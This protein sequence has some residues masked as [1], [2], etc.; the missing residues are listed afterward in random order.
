MFP[1]IDFGE[2]MGTRL[3]LLTIM[4]DDMPVMLAF[5]RDNLGFLVKR[6][7]GGWVSLQ[8]EGMRLALWERK[9]LISQFPNVDFPAGLNGTFVLA[10]TFS[11]RE[12]LD[13][14]FTRIVQAGAR[15]VAPL[16]DAP[17]WDMRSGWIA[18]P[19]GNLIELTWHSD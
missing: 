2:L 5:Y 15:E 9:G 19:E 4:V 16:A 7:R 17:Q 8:N 18:D 13:Q 14:E 12:A 10:I 3:D 1:Y 6:D 11:T